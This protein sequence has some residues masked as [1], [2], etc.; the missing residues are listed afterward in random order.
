MKHLAFDT[1]TCFIPAADNAAITI[2]VTLLHESQLENWRQDQRT[3]IQTQITQAGFKANAGEVLITYGNGG[4]IHAVLCGIS[5]PVQ[6]YD[7]ASLPGALRKALS[8]NALQA[9]TFEFDPPAPSNAYLGWALGCYEFT[10]YKKPTKPLPK[11]LTHE[12]DETTQAYIE[13]ISLLRNM[14]NLPA[15]D[16]GP[17]EIEDIAS[18]LAITHKA[19]I[20]TVRGTALEKGFPLVHAV[21]KAAHEKRAPRLIEINWGPKDAPLIALVGKGVCFDTGG[22]DLKPSAYMALMKKDMG[23]SAHALALGHLIMSLK[24]PVR[25]KIVIA[26]VENAVGSDAFRPGDIFTSRSGKTVENTDTDAE[27]RLILADALT[28][29]SESNPELIID[30]ATLTGSAR[31]ALGMDIP[32]VFPNANHLEDRIR[33]LSASIQDPLWPMPLHNGYNTLLESN[34]ADLTNHVGVPGDLIYS[35]L[36]LQNF[37]GDKA[38]PHWIH[39]DCFAWEKSGRPGRPVGGKDTGLRGIFALLEELY[40]R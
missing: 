7:T 36:F 8:A 20:K 15:N 37:V 4:E 5:D 29:A 31:A 35:A 34:I 23:G 26:A 38:A 22:L 14:I 11:L 32:A 30:F 40:P 13:A 19:K 3:E 12:Q 6:I 10:P 16:L 24:L 9:L 2:P 27:G 1:P 39:V 17:A 18:D 28:F 33:K 21:G 25:L